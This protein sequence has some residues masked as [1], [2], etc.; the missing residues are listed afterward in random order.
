MTIAVTECIPYEDDHSQ[1]GMTQCFEKDIS[2]AMHL[3]S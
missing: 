2:K 3:G 1:E